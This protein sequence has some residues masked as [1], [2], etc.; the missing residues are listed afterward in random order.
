MAAVERRSCD[1]SF[2]RSERQLRKSVEFLQESAKACIRQAA[3]DLAS[4]CPA[5]RD[6]KTSE[7]GKDLKKCLQGGGDFSA[8]LS[9][10]HAYIEENRRRVNMDHPSTPL[11]IIYVACGS[12]ESAADALVT[13]SIDDYLRIGMYSVMSRASSGD[14][15]S[16]RE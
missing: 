11:D 3:L 10:T 13:G 7:L 12:L 2:E 9:V 4:A 1:A 16:A 6:S 5:V 15:L 14:V 8:I